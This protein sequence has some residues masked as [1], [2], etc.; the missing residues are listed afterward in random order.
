MVYHPFIDVLDAIISFKH[1]M[2]CERFQER[3]V[4][5]LATFSKH[6]FAAFKRQKRLKILRGSTKIRQSFVWIIKV[7]FIP[8]IKI[9]NEMIKN[10]II[11]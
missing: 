4:L 11:R 9:I 10:V 7:K 8:F 6:I 5:S 1:K 3:T 2:F